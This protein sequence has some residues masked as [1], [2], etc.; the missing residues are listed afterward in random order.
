MLCN[1]VDLIYSKYIKVGVDDV[2]AMGRIKAGQG[3]CFVVV[4]GGCFL[5]VDCIT[6]PYGQ[7]NSHARVDLRRA[8]KGCCQHTSIV[9]QA[10]TISDLLCVCSQQ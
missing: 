9:D 3:W 1:N 7:H 2:G 4:V 10:T 6:M 8:I 5:T